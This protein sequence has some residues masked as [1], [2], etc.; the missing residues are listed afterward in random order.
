MSTE[1]PQ[2]RRSDRLTPAQGAALLGLAGDDAPASLVGRPNRRTLAALE[3]RG[4][5][6]WY[7]RHGSWMLTDDGQAKVAELRAAARGEI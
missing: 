4:L 1:N 7:S 5:I 3:A 2:D 6:F